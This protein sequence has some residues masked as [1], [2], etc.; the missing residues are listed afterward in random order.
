MAKICQFLCSCLKYPKH[1]IDFHLLKVK[2][3]SFGNILTDSFLFQLAESCKRFLSFKTADAFSRATFIDDSTLCFFQ[4]T[5]A[6]PQRNPLMSEG[7][8]AMLL[9]RIYQHLSRLSSELSGEVLLQINFMS[10]LWGNQNQP[11]ITKL[12]EDFGRAILF[13]GRK[14]QQKHIQMLICSHTQEDFIE[15][16]Y[17]VENREYYYENK[18]DRGGHFCSLLSKIVLLS[19]ILFTHIRC[20]KFSHVSLF[21][22]FVFICCLTL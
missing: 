16:S 18:T 2:I 19:I 5:Q 9:W 7:A 14:N 20:Q 4:W 13:W 12:L 8:T 17:N 10:A 3:V 11:Q 6:W 21:T 1:N 22:A 15:F